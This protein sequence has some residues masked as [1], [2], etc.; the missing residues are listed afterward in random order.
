MLPTSRSLLTRSKQFSG[1]IRNL[2]DKSGQKNHHASESSSSHPLSSWT[3][4][5]AAV[6]AGVGVAG[7]MAAAVFEDEDDSLRHRRR[8]RLFSSSSSIGGVLAASVPVKSAADFPVVSAETSLGEKE[9]MAAPIT[10]VDLLESERDQ[11][12]RKMEAFIMGLQ[13]KICKELEELEEDSKFTVRTEEGMSV[14][15]A[16]P[17]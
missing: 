11:M 4:R 7:W 3:A 1:A 10:D 8:R 5:A 9:W 6:V 16:S 2:A 15:F 12:R 13:G 14:P 17:I